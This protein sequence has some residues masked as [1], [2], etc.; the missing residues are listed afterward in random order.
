MDLHE[1]QV[2]DSKVYW[3]LHPCVSPSL[4]I[5]TT[6]PLSR[7]LQ[8]DL[9]ELQVASSEVATIEAALGDARHSVAEADAERQRLAAEG[10]AA[11]RKKDLLDKV[12]GLS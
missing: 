10:P 3:D 11:Y 1:L 4:V 8:M 2:A 7:C 5:F 6:I 9:H 12:G